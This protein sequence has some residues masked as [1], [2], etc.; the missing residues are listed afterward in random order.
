MTGIV[1]PYRGMPI[2]T[3]RPIAES[4]AKDACGS[5]YG[6]E[7]TADGHLADLER[8]SNSPSS[9][10]LVLVQ[11]AP[12]GYIGIEFWQNPLG[13]ELVASEKYWYVLP[14][15]RGRDSFRLLR[16]AKKC[17]K[18][19]GASYMFFTAS[20][21]AGTEHDRVCRLYE[22]MGFRA[23]ETTYITSLDAEKGA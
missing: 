16:E 5:Q 21:L 12:V 23:F 13:S 17:A 1:I 4:W 15:A 14:D 9:A 10:L 3:L 20:R 18:Q 6:I 22:H 7:I 19:A 11:A 2:E 8:L